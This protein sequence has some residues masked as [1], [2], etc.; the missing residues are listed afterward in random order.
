MEMGSVGLLY[1][2]TTTKLTPKAD[3]RVTVAWHF[4]AK[5]RCMYIFMSGARVHGNVLARARVLLHVH[6]QS[7]SISMSM[8]IFI[9]TIMIHA[10]FIITAAVWYHRKS[11]KWV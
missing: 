10:F 1:E 4:D 9:F 8:F 5:F 3:F 6:V 11:A 2:D 7:V